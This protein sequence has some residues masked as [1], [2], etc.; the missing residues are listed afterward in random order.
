MAKQVISFRASEDEVEGLKQLQQPGDTGL[1]QVV[2]RLVRTALGLSY[3]PVNSNVNVGR[4]EGVV[5]DEIEEHT[6]YLATAMNE[7]KSQLEDE[8]SLLKLRLGKLE[9]VSQ[10]NSTSQD[11]PETTKLIKDSFLEENAI[12]LETT[13]QDVGLL[14]ASRP[15]SKNEL[16]SKINSIS[17]T[18]K[19][20][21]LKVSEPI[22]KGK[23]TEMYPNFEDWVSEDTRKE[24]IKAL[25]KEVNK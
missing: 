1:S 9:A 4:V 24:V 7:V 22:I 23:I 15:L 20:H 5:V 19:S 10:V 8:I 2:S 11:K 25:E 12:A 16:K 17:R 14:Q 18:L 6:A 13:T 3:T 21:G